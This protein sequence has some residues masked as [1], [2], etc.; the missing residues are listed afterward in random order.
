[1]VVVVVV[2]VGVVVCG[3][4]MYLLMLLMEM[5][6]R[7]RRGGHVQP[8]APLRDDEHVARPCVWLQPW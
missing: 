7:L 2:V 6:L 1:M 4:W 5:R 3:A 8:G